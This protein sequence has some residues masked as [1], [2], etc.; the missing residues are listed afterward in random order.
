[1]T[2]SAYSGSDSPSIP[3]F[4]SPLHPGEVVGSLAQLGGNPFAMASG[5]ESLAVEYGIDPHSLI[6]ARGSLSG[7]VDA[8][9]DN[10]EFRRAAE[11]LLGGAVDVSPDGSS[12]VFLG[13]GTARPD[14]G[15][16]A[17]SCET[18]SDA[19]RALA[20]TIPRAA[21]TPSVAAGMQ[22]LGR[23]MPTDTSFLS[24]PSLSVEEKLVMLLSKIED[25]TDQ[26]LLE[27]AK[28]MDQSH[29]GGGAGGFG[30]VVGGIIGAVG[31]AL[32]PVGSIVGGAVGSAV[33]GAING[34]AG[35][36][37]TD[38]SQL[39]ARLQMLEQR[40]TEISKLVTNVLEMEHES[41]MGFINN[42]R[43]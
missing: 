32:G 21:I 23:A 17:A 31:S 11:S 18:P 10:P 27:T 20:A 19:S 40:K 4:T 24:D 35:G 12:F 14:G 37:A 41:K 7:L 16:A 42:L 38:S 3:S 5:L 36:G 26:E 13:P 9:R 25:A 8:M 30:Q 34:A 43:A 33:S 2:I 39:Q 15:A 22:E 1:M 28:K 6:G 29:N